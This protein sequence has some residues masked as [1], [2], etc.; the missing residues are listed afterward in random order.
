MSDSNN[1]DLQAFL[2]YLLNQA[3]EQS[4]LAF[5]RSYKNRYNMLRTEWRVMFHL[6]LFGTMTA[7]DIGVRGKIH[8]TKISRAVQKLTE[9]RFILRQRSAED[10]RQESLQL[11]VSGR[12]AFL[13]LR[14]TAEQYQTDLS[15]EFSVEEFAL[16]QT[17]LKR[18]IKH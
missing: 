8:K 16:L 1:F 15:A 13:E 10:R 14:K 6:G 9:K 3:A 2:P 4:S 7:R 17:M 12:A 5:Q 18:L 11:T